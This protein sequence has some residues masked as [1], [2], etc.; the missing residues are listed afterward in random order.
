[1]RVACG[2]A[3]IAPYCNATVTLQATAVHSSNSGLTVAD[4]LADTLTSC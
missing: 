4:T 2:G 3:M 1:M